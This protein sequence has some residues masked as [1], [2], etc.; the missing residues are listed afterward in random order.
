MA[1]LASG[2]SERGYGVNLVLASAKGPYLADVGDGVRV[3]DLDAGSIA[4]SALPL[5]RYLRDERPRT[6]LSA[7]SHANVVACFAKR[8]ARSDARLVV[9]ER[10]SFAAAREHSRGLRDR[11]VHKL[12][13]PAYRHAQMIVVVAEAMI[14]EMVDLLGLPRE[15]IVCIYN[16]VVDACLLANAAMPNDHP[17]L[18]DTSDIPVVLGCGRL[19]AQKDFS[20]LIEAFAIL[21]QQREARLLIL[22]EGGDR[23]ELE[24]LIERRGLVNDVSLPGFASN[25]FSYMRRAGV[26]VL[27][28]IYEGMPGALI[29]AMACGA[30]VISTDCPTGPD[31]ILEHGRWGRLVPARDARAMAQAILETL[32]A[33]ETALVRAEAFARDAAV[34]RY[35]AALGLE[36]HAPKR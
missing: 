1:I 25:P 8:M 13:R 15:R 29:Q 12:M 2:F 23:R 22:G 14:D 6:I 9:S 20:T 33:P 21:R 17:W 3:V 5:A 18:A 10:L 19:T 16:P 7:M 28:S 34:T 24:E 4:M 36:P 11:I 32:D 26:F 35:L 31:E 27:S 30:P